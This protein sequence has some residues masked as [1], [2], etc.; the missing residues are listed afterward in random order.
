MRVLDDWLLT[1]SRAAVHLPT[2]TAVVAD[3]HLGYSEA[4]RRAGEAVPARDV[5]AA[6]APLAAALATHRVR[7]LVVAGDLF[8]SGHDAAVAADLRAW[9][10]GAG[11]GLAGIVPGN[12]DGDLSVSTDLPLC[13]GGFDLGDWRIVHGDGPL[14]GG[15]VV[16]GHE[17]PWLRWNGRVGGPC[18]LVAA[19]RLVLPAF[20]L[21]AAGVNVRRSRRWA[22]FHCCVIAGDRVLDFGAIRWL[23]G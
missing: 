23:G 13:L 11:V 20:S 17:H 16:Q 14:P 2:A 9:L 12:H 8:E 3:L 19:D 15:K 4:R 22:D 18:Y 21:D 10:D 7:R 1:P 6:L 5:A